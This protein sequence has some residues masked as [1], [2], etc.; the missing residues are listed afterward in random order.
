MGLK[1]YV[2]SL[3]KAGFLFFCLGFSHSFIPCFH[4][5]TVVEFPSAEEDRRKWEVFFEDPCLA[6]CYLNPHCGYVEL[7]KG[8]PYIFEI[9][10]DCF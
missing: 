3:T 1:S 4:C 6:H 8:L 2:E 9:F 7:A 10:Q 5:G